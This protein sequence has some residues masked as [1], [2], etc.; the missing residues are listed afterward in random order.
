[1]TK[2]TAPRASLRRS[3]ERVM[4]EKAKAKNTVHNAT[5]HAKN[6]ADVAKGK[7]K[8]TTGKV[9]GDRSMQVEGKMDVAK[10]RAKQVGQKAKETFKK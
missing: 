2:L 8:A 9:V 6:A 3:K 7:V 4:V 5:S 1:M 10:G